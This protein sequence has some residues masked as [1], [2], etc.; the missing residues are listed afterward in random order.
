MLISDLATRVPQ[1]PIKNMKDISESDYK[2]LTVGPG[3]VPWDSF[4]YG[5]ELRKKF[6]AEKMEPFQQDFKKLGK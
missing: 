4:K 3:S 1:I 2:V 5:N 6:F